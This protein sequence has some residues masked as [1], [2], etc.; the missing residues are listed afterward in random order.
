V[1]VAPEREDAARQF[2]MDALARYYDF[3]GLFRWKKKFDPVF[4]D[5]YLVFEDPL[6]LPR[7]ARALLRVQTPAGLWSYLRLPKPGGATASPPT[8][9]RS[10]SPPREKVA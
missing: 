7:V 5:R 10:H 9:P 3:K 1:A 6:T 8:A 4:E 2:L